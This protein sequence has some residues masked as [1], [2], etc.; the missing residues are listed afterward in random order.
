MHTRSSPP[1]VVT[2]YAGIATELL[3]TLFPFIVIGIVYGYQNKI[4]QLWTTSEWSV[5]AAV[6]FGQSIVKLYALRLNSVVAERI[7]L[8]STFVM[9]LGFA[10]SLIVLCL[11]LL[12]ENTPS[13]LIYAQI[14]LFILSVCMFLLS[15]GAVHFLQDN[16]SE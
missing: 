7:S 4:N 14:A 2:I 16:S 6:L 15:S 9:I 3:F 1:N 12:S 10:P 8:V 11:I 13:Y 5:A